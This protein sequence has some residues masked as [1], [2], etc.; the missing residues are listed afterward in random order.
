MH[1]RLPRRPQQA[2]LSRRASGGFTLVELLVV[3]AVIALLV[4]ILLP[5]LA[6]ARRASRATA[7]L[8]S[9]RGLV[10][11]ALLYALDHKD[12]VPREGTFDRSVPPALLRARIPWPVALRPY[13]DPRVSPG[14]DVN[15][16]FANA[17]YYRCAD[18]AASGHP[19]HYVNNGFSFLRPGVVDRRAESLSSSTIR[20]RRSLTALRHVQNP[21][22]V[23]YFAELAADP[24]DVL[25][26]RW[27][28][29]GPDDFSISQC[30]DVWL[31]KHLDSASTDYRIDPRRHAGSSSVG[32]FDG[33]AA[34]TPPEVV[35][36]HLAWDDGWYGSG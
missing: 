25:L 1:T 31:P 28:A 21:A 22:R 29:L 5:A 7:C 19:I 4:G 2:R 10:Q 18:R 11:G 15:D 20:F 13:L 6:G 26:R 24:G 33:H 17:P 16:Y 35:L 8:S 14:Q 3:I 30:Y 23:P 27:K 36:N 9:V 32:F 12:L 34:S